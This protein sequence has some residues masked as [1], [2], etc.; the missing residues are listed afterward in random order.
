MTLLRKAF[1]CQEQ[2]MNDQKYMKIHDEPDWDKRG[3]Y[4]QVCKCGVDNYVVTQCDDDPE[5]YT[6]IYTFCRECGETIEWTLPV[7]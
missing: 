7:N 5:Y 2:R 4:T 3:I 1:H 6:K